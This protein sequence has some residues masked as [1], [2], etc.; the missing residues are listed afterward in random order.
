MANA[1]KCL[2]RRAVRFSL[3]NKSRVPVSFNRPTEG[4]NAE[5]GDAERRPRK[6][7]QTPDGILDKRNGLGCNSSE[8]DAYRSFD[9]C[10][11]NDIDR[12]PNDVELLRFRLHPCIEMIVFGADADFDCVY[13]KT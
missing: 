12:Y 8:C 7:K 5:E 1:N 3:Q 10:D 6:C 11:G 13:G 9:Q 4:K 2:S